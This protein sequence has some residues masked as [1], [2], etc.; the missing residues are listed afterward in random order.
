MNNLETF[1]LKGRDG[2]KHE[3]THTPL[4]LDKSIRVGLALAPILGGVVG[5]LVQGLVQTVIP[6]AVAAAA[7]GAGGAALSSLLDMKVT[8]LGDI[9][10]A[11]QGLNVAE[12][13]T[14]FGDSVGQVDPATIKMLVSTCSRDGAPLSQPA[15]MAAAFEKN[16]IELG[17]LVA[18]V[19]MLEGFV[20]FGFTLPSAGISTREGAAPQPP[21]TSA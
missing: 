17:M 4:P 12:V 16:P 21:A 18:K 7:G 1:S 10:G 2:Q 8:Q 19:M 11:V 13:L 9:L 5:E 6:K 20:D 14:K 15:N 3:Y